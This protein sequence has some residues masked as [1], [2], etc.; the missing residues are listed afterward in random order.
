MHG[1]L[2]EPVRYEDEVGPYGPLLSPVD[3]ERYLRIPASTVRTWHRRRAAGEPGRRPTGLWA[4]GLDVV[5]RPLFYMADLLV[6]AH[7]C[8]I[9]GSSGGRLH[10]LADVLDEAATGRCPARGGRTA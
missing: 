10:T 3:A 9:W 1:V 8:R 4:E 6:L 5:G 7:G 2:S